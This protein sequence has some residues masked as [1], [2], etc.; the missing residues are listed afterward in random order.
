MMSKSLIAGAWCLSS[1]AAIASIIYFSAKLIED[2]RANAEWEVHL[3][4]IF[5]ILFLLVLFSTSAF[6]VLRKEET[7]QS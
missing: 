3:M 6:Q 2:Y 1:I 5:W 4:R 7:L